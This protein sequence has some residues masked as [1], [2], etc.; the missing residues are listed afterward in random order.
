MVGIRRNRRIERAGVNA[1]R[2]V[3]EDAGHIV[4]E[5]DGANDHGEDLYVRFVDKG[6]LTSSIVAIQVK[7]GTKYRRAIGYSIPVGRHAVL[8]RTSNIPVVGVVYD[9]EMQMLY[10]GNITERLRDAP[11]DKTVAIGGKRY[12]DQPHALNVLGV[13]VLAA[14]RVRVDPTLLMSE[15]V[16]EPFIVA[17][18]PSQTIIGDYD[19]PTHGCPVREVARPQDP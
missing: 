8:W 6:R 2:T 17:G 3:L 7:S 1:L 19:H 5:I 11:N 14:T 18:A 10:W 9:P 15:R 13:Q 16:H 4:Q 12:P